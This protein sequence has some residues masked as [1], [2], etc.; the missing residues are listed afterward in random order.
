VTSNGSDSDARLHDFVVTE[1]MATDDRAPEHFGGCGL[2]VAGGGH[3]L[4]DG[5]EISNN[6]LCGVMVAD[7][8]MDLSAGRVSGSPIGANVQASGFDITRITSGVSFSNNSLNL[9]TT[10]ITVPAVLQARA[11]LDNN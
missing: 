7:G 2:V 9:D 10:N 6:A 5:F 8:G 4:G 11:L 3:I 1:T